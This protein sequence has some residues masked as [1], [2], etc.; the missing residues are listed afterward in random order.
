V[1]DSATSAA[2]ISFDRLA[3]VYEESRGGLRRGRLYAARVDPHLLPGCVLEIGIGMA[4][5]ALPLSESGRAVVGVDLSPNMLQLAHDRLGNRVA[6]ADVMVLPIAT[7]SLPNVLAVWVL[8]L[9][10]SVEA[11]LREARRVLVDGGRLVV[12]P[13]RGHFSADD[14]DAVSVDFQTEIRGVRQ[15]DPERIEAAGAKIG[16]RLVEAGATESMYFDDTPADVVRSIEARRFGILLDLG[17]DDWQRVV[18]PAL[19]ALRSL[20]DQDRPRH[21]SSWHDLLVF[22]AV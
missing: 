14:I 8:Q 13:S 12:V 11:T 20:P 18:L 17:D 3:S 15:D 1:S 22:E 19:A 2:S 10:S 4:T 16:L 5:V 9:V 21:R 7:A 6:V